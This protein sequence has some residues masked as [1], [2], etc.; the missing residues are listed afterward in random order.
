[1]TRLANMKKEFIEGKEA[2]D[3]FSEAMKTMFRTSKPPKHK[4]KKRKKG[5]D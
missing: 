4:P 5:K 3:R 2:M 1:M